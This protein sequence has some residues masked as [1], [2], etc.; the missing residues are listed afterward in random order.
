VISSGIEKR[1]ERTGI[2]IASLINQVFIIEQKIQKAAKQ[3]S[4]R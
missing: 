3:K 2:K 1:G 4:A